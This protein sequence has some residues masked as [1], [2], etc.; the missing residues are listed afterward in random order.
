MRD[1][2]ALV[3]VKTALC[4]KYMRLAKLAGSKRKRRKFKSKADKY[5]RQ[6]LD[7]FREKSVEQMVEWGFTPVY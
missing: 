3:R 5:R 7:L 6:A 1:K 4:N 2:M